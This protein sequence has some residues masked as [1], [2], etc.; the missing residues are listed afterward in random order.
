MGNVKARLLF[1]FPDMEDT[2]DAERQ[3]DLDNYT[4][5]VRVVSI[6][7]VRLGPCNSI[8]QERL[9]PAEIRS[10]AVTSHSSPLSS[11]NEELAFTCRLVGKNAGK[12]SGVAK[13]PEA[14]E[15]DLA[16]STR[17]NEDNPHD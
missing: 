14:A 1:A 10:S 2:S 3:Q 12:E 11:S 7:D 13:A 16:S 9:A 15:D 5:Q 8:C 4:V 17:G 6:M